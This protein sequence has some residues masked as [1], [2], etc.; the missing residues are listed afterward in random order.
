MKE[1]G[2]G[3]KHSYDYYLNSKKGAKTIEPLKNIIISLK[4]DAD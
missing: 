2:I 3:D 1:L 4:D